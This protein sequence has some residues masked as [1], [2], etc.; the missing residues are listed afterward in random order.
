[1]VISE[2]V[3]NATVSRRHIRLCQAENDSGDRQLLLS[4]E[5]IADDRTLSPGTLLT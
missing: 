3:G 5:A 2:I 4:A 1:M